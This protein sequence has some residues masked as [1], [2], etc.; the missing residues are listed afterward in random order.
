MISHFVH[1]HLSPYFSSYL[2]IWIKYKNKH[3]VSENCSLG[4]WQFFSL[5]QRHFRVWGPPSAS[6]NA[7]RCCFISVR[8]CVASM[9]KRNICLVRRS[10][11]DDGRCSWC[12]SYRK[13]PLG[14]A[15]RLHKEF[16][17]WTI[18]LIKSHWMCIVSSFLIHI[19]VF[20]LHL[21]IVSFSLHFK[22]KFIYFFKFPLKL[23]CAWF[24]CNMYILFYFL[25][26][27][28]FLIT[29]SFV[30]KTRTRDFGV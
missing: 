15:L 12:V 14:G 21:R 17:E 28:T 18:K 30:D 25:L 22:V 20:S 2:S 26:N 3:T 27:Q 4:R 16:V 1:P 29:S 13:A 23:N 5:P 9:L 19:V 7:I 24:Y 11:T 8:L 10:P 6:G